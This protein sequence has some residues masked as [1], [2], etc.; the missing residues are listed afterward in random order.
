MLQHFKRV[1]ANPRLY[2]MFSRLI[3]GTTVY[4]ALIQNHLRPK[5]GDKL[6]DIGCGAARILEFLPEVSYTGFDL[7]EQYIEMAQK[8]YG[9]RGRFFCKKISREAWSGTAEFDL[10]LASGVVHHLSDAEA[11]ALFEV[12]KSAL[13]QGGRLVTLDGCYDDGQSGITRYLLSRDRGQYV[14]NR[15]AYEKLATQ[16]FPRTKVLI[17]HDLL[18]IPYTHI[19]MECEAL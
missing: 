5:P 12:A 15:E 2:L 13:K 19:I 9:K 14:R 11:I 10:V 17:R 18:R 7:S 16:V 4:H 3:G 8:R 1:L 6:L